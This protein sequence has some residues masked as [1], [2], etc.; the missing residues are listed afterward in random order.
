MDF[1]SNF[2][3]IVCDPQ[4]PVVLS[5]MSIYKIRVILLLFKD[6]SETKIRTVSVTIVM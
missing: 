5:F 2:G 4:P 3:F 1:N 6:C